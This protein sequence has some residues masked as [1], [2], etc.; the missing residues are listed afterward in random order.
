MNTTRQFKMNKLTRILKTLLTLVW[1]LFLGACVAYVNIDL[2]DS[3]SDVLTYIIATSSLCYVVTL[4]F[5]QI[6]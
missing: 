5:E 1:M 2:F 4:H 3:P 6:K